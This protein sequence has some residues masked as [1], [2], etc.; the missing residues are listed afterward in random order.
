LVTFFTAVFM[1]NS[2]LVYKEKLET[3]EVAAHAAQT[4]HLWGSSLSL[5]ERT[6]KLQDWLSRFSPIFWMS[7]LTDEKGNLV[8]S[9]KRY[10]YTVVLNNRSYQCLGIGAV[11]TIEQYSRQGQAAK[12]IEEVCRQSKSGMSTQLAMLYS[13]IEPAYYQRLGFHLLPSSSVR[14]KLEQIVT[15]K[16]QHD[17]DTNLPK[18]HHCGPEMAQFFSKL[19]ERP[20]SLTTVRNV[21]DWNMFKLINGLNDDQSN[22]AILRTDG[23]IVAHLTFSEIPDKKMLWVE[24]LLH[25]PGMEVALQV[26]FKNLLEKK[27]LDVLASWHT[28][29]KSLNL[30]A[31]TLN[32]KSAIGMMRVLDSEIELSPKDLETADFQSLHHF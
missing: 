9:L 8:T 18:D 31:E 1:L 24:E 26:A 5:E 6:V 23:E 7:G 13:D 21:T 28:G 25:L 12:L 22:E 10:Y 15:P 27:N 17:W 4:H 32:R 14:L 19:Q 30:P 3:H 16:G 11:Y 29:L 2:N 20:S